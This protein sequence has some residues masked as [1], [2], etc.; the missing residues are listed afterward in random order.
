MK[1][2]FVEGFCPHCGDNTLNMFDDKNNLIFTQCKCVYRKMLSYK[3]TFHREMFNMDMEL[4][5]HP[6]K[7]T[8]ILRNIVEIVE[9]KDNVILIENNKKQHEFR[10]SHLREIK[11][12]I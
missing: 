11:K 10:K 2:R 4:V 6:D 8:M 5:K 7:K 1:K 12:I 3:I 9:D